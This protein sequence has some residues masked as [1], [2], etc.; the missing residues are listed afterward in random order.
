M[1]RASIVY[2]CDGHL[3]HM[4]L[5]IYINFCSPFPR[6][7]HIKLDFDWLSRFR[8]KIIEKCEWTA[9]DNNGRTDE[10]RSM[11]LFKKSRVV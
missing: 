7:L 6:R 2:G 3:G 11:G 8:A 1:F 5:S 10:R 9:T 4:T